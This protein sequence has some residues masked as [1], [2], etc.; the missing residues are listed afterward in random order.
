MEVIK[1]KC[2]YCGT[3]LSVKPQQGL[4]T[5]NVTC[6]V[7]G[8]KSPFKKFKVLTP[9]P[10]ANDDVCTSCASIYKGTS[11]ENDPVGSLQVL[12]PAPL[13][14]ELHAGKNIIGRKAKG[15]A[16]DIQIPEESKRMSREHLV[17]EV[18]KVPG[19]GW[20][21]YASLFKEKVN[22]TY[23]NDE[24]LEYGDRIVLNPGDLLKL[25]GVN[26]KFD[27]ADDEATSL[28]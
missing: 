8:E 13:S 16:A 21:H 14:F 19:K 11:S 25:P 1:I 20:V 9:R 28:K 4:E 2:P 26:V 17:V 23:V 5:K 18:K 27:I 15:S 7:C 22:A 6:P 10:A 3:V 24:L 12:T